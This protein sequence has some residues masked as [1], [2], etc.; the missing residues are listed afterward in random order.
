MPACNGPVRY[1]GQAEVAR[2]LAN[3]TDALAGVQVAEAFLTA[4]S[5]GVIALFLENQ[6]YPTHE[7]YLFALAEAMKEEYDAIVGAGLLLQLDCPDLSVGRVRGEDWRE[8]YRA[9]HIKALNLAV[10]DIPP[11]RLRLHLCWGN[12]EGPHHRDTPLRTILPDVLEARPTALSF[13]GANRRHEHEWKVFEEIRLP[14]EKI[15]IPGV[16]DS[17][18]N[19]IE[20]PE[21]VAQH[22]ERYASMVGREHVIA[23]TDCGFATFAGSLT[24]D[25]GITWA[26]LAAMVEGAQIA[27]S[28]LWQAS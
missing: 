7:A 28:R 23:G 27:S 8:D 16:L 20:H 18:T 25:P 22:S 24:V 6:Y 21:L 10:R 2:D 4:A 3:L 1:R 9:L 12:Y 13:E 14:Q 26:K 5:P 17:T 19:F 15:I 11:D